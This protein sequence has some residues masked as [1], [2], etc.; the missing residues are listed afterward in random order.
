LAAL[1]RAGGARP[2]VCVLTA[3]TLMA[4]PQLA[5]ASGHF[6]RL[7]TKVHRVRHR[8]TR[9]AA[10]S[11]LTR[12][13]NADLPATSAPAAVMEAAVKCLT[14]QQRAKHGLPILTVSWR[15]R[16]VAQS[17]STKMVLS[18]E[19]DHGANFAARIGAAG[20][21]WQTA[22]EN[23][24]TGYPT[25]RSVV[26]AWMASPDHCR[27]ILDP[28]F[29]SIG[30]GVNKAPVGGFATGPS[31]WTQDFGLLMTQSPPSH[32]HGPQNGC[33]Y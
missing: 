30:A 17:W 12:C 4:T 5:A 32:N 29:R 18:G 1:S 20:Y 10:T 28:S 6:G 23:I 13:A 22:G 15:L 19:F 27:N 9:H 26:T 7:D 11:A 16:R 31:T 25:P 24:A 33:P 21:D 2:L 3:A 8:A 14:N